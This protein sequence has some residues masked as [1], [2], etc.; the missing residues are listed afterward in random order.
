MRYILDDPELT[1]P[2]KYTYRWI[3]KGEMTDWLKQGFLSIR[4]SDDAVGKYLEAL[5]KQE[6]SLTPSPRWVM[7]PGDEGLVVRRTTAGR[8]PGRQ[9]KGQTVSVVD[10]EC[11]EF[12]IIKRIE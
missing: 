7:N 10:G 11:W 9:E 12:G 5:L 1:G 4:I 3:N 6:V 8:D 2:G